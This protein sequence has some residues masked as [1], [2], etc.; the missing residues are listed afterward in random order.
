ME[1]PGLVLQELVDLGRGVTEG[2]PPSLRDEHVAWQTLVCGNEPWVHAARHLG[3]IA[4]PDLIR[5]LVRY[6]RAS[7][8]GIGGSVSPVI[9]LYRIVVEQL[10]SAEPELTGWVVAHRTNPYEPFGTSDDEGASTYAEYVARRNVQVERSFAN[11]AQ[12]A[13][14]QQRGAEARR[15]RERQ[16]STER[17]ANAVRRGDLA[18][19]QALLDKGAEVE[20]A[21]PDGGSL[22][23]F[24]LDNGREQV[25]EFLKSRGLR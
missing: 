15:E 25:A 11:K 19:V 20:R 21:L 17:L 4:V 7:G 6:S 2:V 9:V 8:R 14:R 3:A 13:E 24:A 12:E 5:G 22:V 18:A 10:P 16:E 1:L 23:T